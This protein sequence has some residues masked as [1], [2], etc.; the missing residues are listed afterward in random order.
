MAKAE[1]KDKEKK[2]DPT[3][4]SVSAKDS[5]GDSSLQRSEQDSTLSSARKVFGKLKIGN[6]LCQLLKSMKVQVLSKIGIQF[7]M[8]V[9]KAV[10]LK[11]SSF[12][13]V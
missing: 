8:V 3:V 11:G 12:Y 6:I 13:Q 2:L 9:L 10:L 7:T 1:E 4:E 5:G